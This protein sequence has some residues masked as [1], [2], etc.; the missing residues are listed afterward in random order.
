MT[1]TAFTNGKVVIVIV[2][3]HSPKSQNENEKATTFTI[4]PDTYNAD[5][6]TH[7]TRRIYS[8]LQGRRHPRD[9][10]P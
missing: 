9:E 3:S 7:H 4:A 10:D 5:G 6:T 8:N 1:M 2:T